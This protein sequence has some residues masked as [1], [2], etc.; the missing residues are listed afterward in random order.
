MTTD[1]APSIPPAQ[2][3]TAPA[4]RFIERTV[5]VEAEPRAVFARLDDQTRLAEHMAKPSAMMGG[6]AMSYS[7]D[8]GQGRSVGSH[9]LMRGSAFGVSLVVDEVVVVRDPPVRKAWRT[10]GKTRLVILKAYEMGFEVQPEDGGSRLR[11]WIDFQLPAAPA[12]RTV[13]RWLAPWYARWC[14]NRM[15]GDAVAHFAANRA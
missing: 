14:V 13:G 3:P 7:F 6:G 10:T 5:H 4:V 1:H 9:I 11:V 8:A 15:A 2:P 12:A